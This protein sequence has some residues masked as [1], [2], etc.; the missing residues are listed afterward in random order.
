MKSRRITTSSHPGD[1]SDN[2]TCVPHES[3]IPAS[4]SSASAIIDTVWATQDGLIANGSNDHGRN[5]PTD[6]LTLSEFEQQ[7]IGHELHDG[8]C[9]ELAG[10]AIAVHAIQRQAA[11]GEPVDPAELGG[12]TEL[13][14]SAVRNARGLAH[15][16]YPVGSQP[17]ALP[18]A[19][20]RLAA[21]T[22][23]RF[24]IDCQFSSPPAAA[25]P[26]PIVA[27]H[28]YR[29]AEEAVHYAILTAGASRVV[30][31]L[32]QK[33][34]CWSSPSPPI[35]PAPASPTRTTIACRPP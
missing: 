7:Q 32:K 3:A 28:L 18:V 26:D 16:L 29:I 17:N 23:E 6:V 2:P 25:T 30:I 4:P 12:I 35:A 11:S 1:Q 24:S 5:L 31:D 19:L 21:H 15:R 22:S 8:L 33:P 14:Q 20:S 13:L 34:A 9:Q 10:I 27:T